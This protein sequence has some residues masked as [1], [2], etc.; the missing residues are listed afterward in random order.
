MNFALKPGSDTHVSDDPEKLR[1]RIAGL[2]QVVLRSEIEQLLLLQV[3]AASQ[4]LADTVKC[5]LQQSDVFS[6]L[7]IA[8]MDLAILAIKPTPETARALE[9]K[10]REQ[11]LQD[12]DEAIYRRRNA[13]IEQERTVKE[14]ELNTE[15][16]VEAK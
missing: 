9:A 12:A 2:V 10:V 6:D 13:S 11:L 1:Q 14:N 15:L 4:S 16:A 7:G 3:L 8:L 5:T